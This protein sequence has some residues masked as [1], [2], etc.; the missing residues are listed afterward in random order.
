LAVIAYSRAIDLLRRRRDH[1]SLEDAVRLDPGSL[2][3][4]LEAPDGF[5]E[6]SQRNCQV[7]RA[8][9]DLPAVQRQLIALAFTQGLCHTEIATATG[10]PIGTVKSHIRRALKR[11]HKMLIG[12]VDPV[13]EPRRFI[14]NVNVN[15]AGS[16][17]FSPP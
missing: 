5:L 8:L 4:D 17:V 10:M 15:P 7:A 6:K 13:L 14:A 11:M 12:T 16:R 2:T 9:R 1:L 3:S